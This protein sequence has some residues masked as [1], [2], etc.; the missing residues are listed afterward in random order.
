MNPHISYNFQY[1]STVINIF[2][3]FWYRKIRLWLKLTYMYFNIFAWDGVGL[4]RNVGF[5]AV[6]IVYCFCNRS[7]LRNSSPC[8]MTDTWVNIKESF[9]LLVYRALRKWCFTRQMVGWISKKLWHDSI[10]LGTS[11]AFAQSM[12]PFFLDHIAH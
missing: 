7:R 5:V 11:Y 3:W 6:F 1:K 12:L 4:A 9:N 2:L 8:Y 10:S